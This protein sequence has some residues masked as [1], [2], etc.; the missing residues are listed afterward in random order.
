[1]THALN[2]GGVP[3]RTVDDAAGPL[4]RL[5]RRPLAR[6]I[7]ALCFLYLFLCAMRLISVGLKGHLSTVPAADELITAALG[8]AD[9]PFVALT[10]GVLVTALVQSSSFTTSLIITLVAAGSLEFRAGVF[11]VMG[12]NI[13]TSVTSTIASL[14][15]VRIE[16]QFRRAF[17][18]AIVHDI[19][20]VLTVAVIFPLEWATG[21]VQKSTMWASSSLGLTE[22]EKGTSV[23]KVITRPLVH[24]VEWLTGLTGFGEVGI[25]LVL[26]IGGLGLLLLSLAMMVANLKGALLARIEGLFSQVFFRNDATAYGTGAVTTVLVQSSSITTSLIVPLAGAGAV[27]LHR[28]FPFVLGA[29][30]GTTVTG[31][32]AATSNPQAAAVAVAFAHVVFNLLGAAVW[33]PLR[34]IPINLARRYGQLAARNKL[35]AVVYLLVLFIVVPLVGFIITEFFI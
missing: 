19:F 11:A 28:V 5:L 6:G 9:N 27:R 16:R 26:A 8:Q 12:A 30:L 22:I 4:T 3:S 24:G 10:A 23:V 17:S 7:L 33:Y 35:F 2:P 20:N 25:G 31:L 18:A 21:I 1:V 29:N 15:S 32:I 13:G 14:G 34:R